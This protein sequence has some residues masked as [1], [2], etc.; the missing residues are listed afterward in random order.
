MT[1]C[2]EESMCTRT[3]STTISFRWPLA[4]PLPPPVDM[5]G[6]LVAD[7]GLG[8]SVM[9]GVRRGRIVGDGVGS[10]LGDALGPG[11][12]VGWVVGRGVTEAAGVGEVP[13]VGSS[14]G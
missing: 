6:I 9:R 3:L 12:A 1:T 7:Y 14:D 5:A 11:P 8:A 10:S 4:S 2:C 13:G